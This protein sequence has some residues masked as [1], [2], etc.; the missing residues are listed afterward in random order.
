MEV[1]TDGACSANGQENARAGIG[2]FFGLND[3]RNVS[4]PFVEPPITNQ[5]AELEA[6]RRAI[7]IILNTVPQDK[8][9]TIIS[10]STYSVNCLTTWI[11]GW[12]EN[13]WKGNTVK[14]RD[15]I[16]PTYFLLR[17]RPNISFQICK[18]HRGIYGNEMA[19]KLATAAVDREATI[20]LPEVC[21]ARNK[22][23][24]RTLVYRNE[25]SA[26]EDLMS[27]KDQWNLEF[28][29][30]IESRAQLDRVASSNP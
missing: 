15:I 23:G 4:E 17:R 29:Y 16:E 25:E 12:L 14:N 7:Q 18:G 20:R 13:N 9:V 22:Y 6:I 19:D 24:G 10:D 27:E 3:S 28:H 2:V 26:L 1:Y 21:I 30:L 5:R 8:E 11:K